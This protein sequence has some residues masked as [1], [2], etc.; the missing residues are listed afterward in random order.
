MNN[1]SKKF[2]YFIDVYNMTQFLNILKKYP[3]ITTYTHV[4]AKQ[5]TS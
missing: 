3:S 4:Y 5:S 2:R 1:R